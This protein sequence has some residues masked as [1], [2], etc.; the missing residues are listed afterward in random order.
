MKEV[1]TGKSFTFISQNDQYYTAS[2]IIDPDS[3][4]K[5]IENSR[6]SYDTLIKINLKN[7]QTIL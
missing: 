6:Q 5:K 3:I 7:S 2:L 1:H 4:E